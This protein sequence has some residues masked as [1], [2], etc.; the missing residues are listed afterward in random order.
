MT[1][2]HIQGNVRVRLSLRDSHLRDFYVN[3]REVP[4]G[5]TRSELVNA[6]GEYR[7]WL[8]KRIDAIDEHEI[9]LDFGTNYWNPEGGVWL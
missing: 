9:N 3:C 2:W 8:L 1:S 4:N 5:E 6:L 7:K